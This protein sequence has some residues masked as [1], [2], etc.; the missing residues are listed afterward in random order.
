MGARIMLS[1]A[2]LLAAS[3]VVGQADEPLSNYDALKSFDAIIGCWTL[4]G[5]IL[6]D[7]PDVAKGQKVVLHSSYAWILKKSAVECRST[8]KV[9]EQEA[10]EFLSVYGWDRS[11]GRIVSAIL[12]SN[13]LLGVSEVRV[14]D[15]GKTWTFK[16]QDANPDGTQST[17]TVVM[18]L[19]DPDTIVWQAK[20]RQ[21]GPLTG[22]SPKYTL[23]RCKEKHGGS[24]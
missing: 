9:G 6:E 8:I 21:G 20:D 3:M 17:S 16:A 1:T 18:T 13:G 24:D 19:T 22:D 11:R 2:F 4:E 23:K 12:S 10:A 14:S 15:D 5:Q 7:S